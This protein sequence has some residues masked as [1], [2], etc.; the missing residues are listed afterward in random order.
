[1]AKQRGPRIGT[2]DIETAPITAYVWGLFKVNVGLNQIVKDWTILSWAGKWLGSKKVI[3]QDVSKQTDLR[4]DRQMLEGIWKFLDEADIIIGQNVQSFDVK[5]IN[6][7]FIEAGM[8]PPSPYKVIDTLLMAKQV[9]RFTS[10]KLDWL[11]QRLTAHHKD[12]HDEFPGM[13]LWV[14]CLLGNK[15]AW[16]V[17]RKYNPQD[18]IAT[19][20]VYLR[21]RPY[22]VGHPN[23]AAYFDDTAV[24]CP[25]CGS[26]NLM[27]LEVP[28]L[29]Q[30]GSYTR[31]RCDGCGGFARS[32]YTL[33]S[34]AKRQSLLMN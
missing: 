16:A 3:Y 24:R 25:K 27:A 7:R 5:K 20:D 34:K 31:Y 29:T 21:L 26:A 11:S 13:A 6:A 12:H 22:Y 4:D 30:T 8:P 2:L 19:E 1:M 18:V 9:A 33:N 14:E 32:R 17:M 23:V 15:R 28:A 10:N